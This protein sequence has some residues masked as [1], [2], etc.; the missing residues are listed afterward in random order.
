MGWLVGYLMHTRQQPLITQQQ[1]RAQLA[2]HAVAADAD[3]TH[4]PPW[5]PL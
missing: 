5:C 3:P 2:E 4:W 1:A